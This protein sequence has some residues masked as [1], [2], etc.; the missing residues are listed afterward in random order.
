MNW[1][2]LLSEKRTRELLGGRPS[3]K[4][5]EDTRTEFERDYGRAVFSTPVRRLQDKTQVFPLEAHDSV[6][7]RLTHSVEVSSI[8]RDLAL[9][10]L[11]AV[12]ESEKDIPEAAA[13]HGSTIAATV[14]VLQA[15]TIA[16][17]FSLSKKRPTLTNLSCN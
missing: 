13:S 3:N 7:T 10:A 12:R 15:T 4:P 16:Q 17:T 2:G 5:T 9:R 6:R 1:S 8:A 11:R 14:A